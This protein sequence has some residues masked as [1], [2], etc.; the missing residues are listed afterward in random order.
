MKLEAWY[1]FISIEKLNLQDSHFIQLGDE[2]FAIHTS[3]VS[4]YSV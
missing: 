1:F 3:G 4:V 2:T